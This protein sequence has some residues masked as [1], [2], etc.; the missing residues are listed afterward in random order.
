MKERRWAGRLVVMGWTCTA[1]VLAWAY[2]GGLTSLLAV[3]HVSQP[4][5]TLAS[6]GDHPSMLLLVQEDTAEADLLQ[7]GGPVVLRGLQKVREEGRL[8]QVT[9]HYHTVYLP[10]A[11][12]EPW[13]V[14]AEES[15]ARVMKERHFSL[16]GRCDYYTSRE[17]LISYWYSIILQ[18]NSPLLRA[19]NARVQ[20]VIQGGLYAHWVEAALPNATYC[21]HQP[22]LI[23][24]QDSLSL[25]NLWSFRDPS[26]THLQRLLS[27]RRALEHQCHM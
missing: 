8:R 27:A 20:A 15:S 10:M 16:T 4:F 22:S 13:V 1:M 5:Q 24:V 12:G 23:T 18:K 21:L 26:Q 9:R 3:R 17:V 2:M 19:V 25:T 14:V 11:R 6:L 7:N